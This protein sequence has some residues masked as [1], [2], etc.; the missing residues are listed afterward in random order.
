MNQEKIGHFIRENRKKKQLTQQQL[1]KT[2]KVSNQ[3]ISYWENGKYLPDYE[4]LIPLCKELDIT[5]N[6]LIN[7]EKQSN[8]EEN[9][10]TIE[11]IIN[12]LTYLEQQQINK[13]KTIGKIMLCIGILIILLVLIFISPNNINSQYYVLIGYTTSI[14]SFSYIFK[15]ETVKKIILLNTIFIISLTSV[16]LIQDIFSISIIKYPPRYATEFH[17]THNIIYYETPFYDVY[18]CTNTFGKIPIKGNYKIIKKDY[19]IKD[20]EDINKKK[21]C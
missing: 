15:N 3:T 4:L 5:I 9:K 6:D 17:M 2:L 13:Y 1:A 21:Y 20:F 7:G 11:K 16:L 18:R 14:I 8:E 12:F 19:K 10:K